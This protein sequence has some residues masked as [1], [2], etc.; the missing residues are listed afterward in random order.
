MNNLRVSSLYYFL[1]VILHLGVC[2]VI[3]F[4]TAPAHLTTLEHITDLWLSPGGR[5]L[6][7]LNSSRV[8]TNVVFALSIVF[9]ASHSNSVLIVMAL[10]AW[11]GL[12]FAYRAGAVG[13]LV[14][15]AAGA[16][17]LSAFSYIKLRLK[18]DATF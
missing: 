4:A 2:G 9:V 11:M 5:A 7:A 17:H 10:L 18:R 8:I 15:Y 13:E 12:L 16:I 1:N 6:I 3:F 14:A